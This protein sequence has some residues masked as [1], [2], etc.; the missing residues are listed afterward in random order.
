[1][2]AL[3]PKADIDP[4]PPPQPPTVPRFCLE[5]PLIDMEVETGNKSDV[6]RA[7]MTPHDTPQ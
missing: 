5:F 1:M 3:H 2:S 6:G 7:D 4:Q